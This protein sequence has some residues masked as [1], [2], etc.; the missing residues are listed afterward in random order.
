MEKYFQAEC[1]PVYFLA[2]FWHPSGFVLGGDN[3]IPTRG[4]S[5]VRT[6]SDASGTDFAYTRRPRSVRVRGL[7]DLD[8]SLTVRS[9]YAS[10]L[11]RLFEGIW[12]L[13]VFKCSKWSQ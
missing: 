6:R 10:C 4:R 5:V 8:L 13:F 12:K 3:H 9:F 11:A 1:S 2:E 7:L